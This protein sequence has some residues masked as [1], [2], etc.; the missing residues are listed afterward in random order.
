MD[1]CT[2]GTRRRGDRA[3]GPY[4]YVSCGKISEKVGC[5][6]GSDWVGTGTAFDE[7]GHG[8]IWGV[9]GKV[10]GHNISFL[11]GPGFPV[12]IRRIARRVSSLIWVALGGERLAVVRGNC[13]QEGEVSVRRKRVFDG[14]ALISSRE[15]SDSSS[16][17]GAGVEARQ[18]EITLQ[19]ALL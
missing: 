10:D 12:L 16:N 11:W 14:S 6:I 4:D 18:P 19:E 17:S 1:T 9:Q 8:E 7:R 2:S 3:I 15:V 13:L 5:S